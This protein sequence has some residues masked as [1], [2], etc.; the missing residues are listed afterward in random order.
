MDLLLQFSI[1]SYLDGFTLQGTFMADS[2]TDEVY[3]FLFPADVDDSNRDLAVH[4]PPETETY[5]WSL[6]PEGI[7]HL[8]QDALDELALPC[9]TFQ[10]VV[11][12]FRWRKE[13]YDLIGKLHHAK[14]FDS[15]SRDVAIEL[16]YPLVDVERLNNLINGGKVCVPVLVIESTKKTQHWSAD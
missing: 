3:L 6:N 4:L 12:G 2:P 9:V 13:V 10:V 11:Y 1:S 5:Y 15:T 16:G 7:D 14:G 8:P